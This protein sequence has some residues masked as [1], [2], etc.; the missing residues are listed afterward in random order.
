MGGDSGFFGSE[1]AAGGAEEGGMVYV[2]DP[3]PAIRSGQMTIRTK[4]QMRIIMGRG[5]EE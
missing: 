3:L 1:G 4:R 2:V 5:S